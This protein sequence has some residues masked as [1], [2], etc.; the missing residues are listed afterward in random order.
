MLFSG[1]LPC[2]NYR[3]TVPS[4]ITFRLVVKFVVPSIFCVRNK[5][6]ADAIEGFLLERDFVRDGMHFTEPNLLD[7]IP[8][9]DDYDFPK[10]KNGRRMNIS[11]MQYVHRAGT[12]SVRL[13][14]D[15][16]RWGLLV[17]IENLFYT[18]DNEECQRSTYKILRE[19]Q[20]LETD[21]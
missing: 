11:S 4:L 21:E 1:R 7:C 6:K 18:L 9:G 13:L 19:I 16:Q 20:T 3:A 12:V 17:A 5:E 15:K 14:R 10:Y 8:D 2:C